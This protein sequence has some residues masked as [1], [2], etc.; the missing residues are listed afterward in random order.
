MV[1]PLDG[2]RLMISVLNMHKA[3]SDHGMIDKIRSRSNHS[4]VQRS[5][6]LVAHGA[7]QDR[8][9]RLGL[10]RAAA[11][12]H[13]DAPAAVRVDPAAARAQHVVLVGDVDHAALQNVY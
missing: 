13:P 6:S 5:S 9:G 11:L 8:P 1:D 10:G 2:W 7:A 4:M 12:E 3:V